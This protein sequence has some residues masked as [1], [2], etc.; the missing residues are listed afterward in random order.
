MPSAKVLNPKA[1]VVVGLVL[2]GG[3][4]F[5]AAC[6][7]S[8]SGEQ[9][10]AAPEPAQ[11]FTYGVTAGA[12]ESTTAKLWTRADAAGPVVATVRTDANFP[13]ACA[14]NSEG[15]VWSGTQTASEAHDFTVTFDAAGL[16]SGQTYQ[17][18]FCTPSGD[19]SA[20]GTFKTAPTA[21][22]RADINFA[23]TGDFTA[24]TPR[25]SNSTTPFYDSF[26]VFSSMAKGQLDFAVLGGDV[27]YSDSVAGDRKNPTALTVAEKWEKYRL[28]LR[29]QQ[30][31]QLRA[32]TGEYAHWDD[33]EWDNGFYPTSSNQALFKAGVQAFTDYMPVTHSKD[34]GIYSTYTWGKNLEMFILD[35]TSFRTAPVDEMK[36]KPC[37]NPVTKRT[38]RMPTASKELRARM[39]TLL[40]EP[41]L[42]APVSAAC[43]D[44]IN[45]S[46]RTILG[47]AQFEQLQ[48]DLRAS[49]ATFKVIASTGPMQKFYVAPYG[50]FEGYPLERR[51]MLDLFSK[52]PNV[53]V[54]ATDVHA[55]L[56]GQ[57]DEARPT[58]EAGQ[59][60]EVTVGPAAAGTRQV[61]WNGY[62]RHVPNAT[63]LIASDFF[64]Q[65]KSDG[66]LGMTCANLNT[67]SYATVS[68]T[69]SQLVV[70]P[71]DQHGDPLTDVLGQ[72]CQPLTV[73]ATP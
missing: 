58:D 40:K 57:V 19:H 55:T 16:T 42:N 64:R 12:M 10:N 54:L 30:L 51:R 48:N 13:K 5:L 52:V 8:Q 73:K 17:Y 28:N 67:Y 39:A 37:T 38:E 14:P 56:V 62:F 61:I 2:A 59:A 3:V 63:Q 36:S 34:R 69:D 11:G 6:S 23:Y 71:R 72:Q 9:R 1:S 44:A 20:V 21:N 45:A 49:T 41:S 46:G 7:S 31:Q 26:D 25:G 68:V 47:A 29:Q 35:E 43:T 15:S 27:I 70:T 66:G 18:R 4:L 22:Q 24:E 53:V 65:P 60:M 50:R 32:A 33:H